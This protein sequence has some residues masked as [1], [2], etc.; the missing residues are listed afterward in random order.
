MNFTPVFLVFFAFLLLLRLLFYCTFFASYYSIFCS[1]PSSYCSSASS[2]PFLYF[3]SASYNPFSVPSPLTIPFS[4]LPFRLHPCLPPLPSLLPAYKYFYG[5]ILRHRFAA[6]AA[7]ARG[8][9]PSHFIAPNTR[10][11]CERASYEGERARDREQDHERA[12]ERE[13][14]ENDKYKARKT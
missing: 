10:S 12:S 3:F 9:S 8:C 11:L 4:T 6:A 13:N 5:S 1:F 7:A 14:K 2:Y